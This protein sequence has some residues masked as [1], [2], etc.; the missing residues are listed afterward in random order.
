MSSRTFTEIKVKK[1][2]TPIEASISISANPMLEDMNM[3]VRS[4]K[5]IFS[6]RLSL[7]L[8]RTIT[9]SA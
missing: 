2:N 4:E 9:V 1:P 3:L 5:T 6:K 8:R 7:L